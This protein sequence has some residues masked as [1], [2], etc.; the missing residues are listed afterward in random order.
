M[1]LISPFTWIQWKAD[2]TLLKRGNHNH[3]RRAFINVNPVLR[4]GSVTLVANFFGK[5][6]G[7]RVSLNTHLASCKGQARLALLKDR[8]NGMKVSK[9]KR[10]REDVKSPEFLALR[11]E[12]RILGHSSNPVC[13]FSMTEQVRL[14]A[15]WPMENWLGS[16]R[17]HIQG[18]ITV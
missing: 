6:G 2:L 9:A 4:E 15:V 13:G 18:C 10:E 16:S 17:N 5:R 11:Q 1:C 7:S 8:R 3:K 12:S 14:C